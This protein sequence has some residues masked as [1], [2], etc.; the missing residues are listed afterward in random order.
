MDHEIRATPFSGMLNRPK[1]K[2]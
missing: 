1:A 2:A